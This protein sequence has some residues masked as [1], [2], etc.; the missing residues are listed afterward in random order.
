MVSAYFGRVMPHAQIWYCSSWGSLWWFGEAVIFCLAMMRRDSERSRRFSSAF[1]LFCLLLKCGGEL[2]ALAMPI[3]IAG[4]KVGGVS[5]PTSCPCFLP[6]EE[7]F[8]GVSLCYSR[9]YIFWGSW[10]YRLPSFLMCFWCLRNVSVAYA[11]RIHGSSC[12]EV[13]AYTTFQAWSWE[14]FLPWTNQF[15]TNQIP[16]RVTKNHGRKWCVRIS[17]FGFGNFFV[18]LDTSTKRFSRPPQVQLNYA[19]D[20]LPW[21]SLGT[22]GSLAD[23]SYADRSGWC[24]TCSPIAADRQ[25]TRQR[26]GKVKTTLPGTSC[27]S[28]TATQHWSFMVEPTIE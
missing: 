5:G 12:P 24:R 21:W 27:Y 14:N 19:F 16:K 2:Q 6:Q 11:L 9:S 13:P 15:E 1:C 28:G 26:S 18:D 8:G 4:P 10:R 17:G 23:A 3:C 22:T 7:G 20:K 25:W